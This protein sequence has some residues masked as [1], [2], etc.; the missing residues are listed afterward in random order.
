MTT[1][2]PDLLTDDEG[3]VVYAIQGEDSEINFTLKDLKKASLTKA[4]I[5]TL[6]ATLRDLSNGNAIINGRN[7]QGIKDDNGGTVT[8]VAGAVNVQLN[9]GPLDNIHSGTTKYYERHSL[10]IEWTYV[11]SLA[12]T[13]TG[14]HLFEVRVLPEPTA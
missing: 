10:L 7:G 1:C 9:L 13:R 8:D 2:I 5:I 12:Q 11:D 3:E 14:K 4:A 6:N